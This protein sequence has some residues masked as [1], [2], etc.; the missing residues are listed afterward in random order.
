[1][2]LL[3]YYYTGWLDT[4]VST[5]AIARKLTKQESLAVFIIKIDRIKPGIFSLK[6]SKYMSP[7]RILTLFI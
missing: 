6:E 5:A 7:K 3:I 4:L 1:M 2:F